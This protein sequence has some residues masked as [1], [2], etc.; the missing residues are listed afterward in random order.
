VRSEAAFAMLAGVAPLEASSGRVTRHRLNRAGDRQ[1]NRALHVIALTRL[2]QDPTTQRHV[3][4]RRAE[5]K[6]DKE[7]RRCLKRIL[8][9]KLF[10]LMQSH[11]L[12]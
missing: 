5:G 12:R 1:L 3:A 4:R 8:A 9:R 7:I 11:P 10:R 2:R 6:S